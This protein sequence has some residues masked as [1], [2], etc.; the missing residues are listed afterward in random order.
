MDEKELNGYVDVGGIM[1]EASNR[2]EVDAIS[3]LISNVEKKVSNDELLYEN[4]IHIQE[5]D[6]T[7]FSKE[8]EEVEEKKQEE[9]EQFTDYLTNEKFDTEFSNLI[10]KIAEPESPVLS[11][12]VSLESEH[13][14][15]KPI[16]ITKIITT[17]ECTYCAYWERFLDLV[18]FHPKVDD[19]LTW[20]DPK[21]SGAILTF[22]TVSLIS[23]GIFSLLSIIGFAV[24]TGMSLVGGYRLYLTIMN[25]V[26]GQSD[27]TFKSFAS[28]KLTLPHD[29]LERLVEFI[30][31]YGNKY[32]EE[33]K[34]IVLWENLYKSGITYL[35]AYVIFSI[36]CTFNTLTLITFSVIF[37]FTW[38]KIYKMYRVQIDQTV[39][40]VHDQLV[41]VIGKIKEK[42]PFLNKRKV[43]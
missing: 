37:A 41:D 7:T 36:G 15:I 38:P 39:K 28:M 26:K 32:I 27:D 12:K 31:T 11:K 33:L 40:K 29:D 34:R 43:E 20:K 24:L 25:K 8:E 30:E 13:E 9:N 14:I 17:S 5:P 19:I 23:F 2:N 1:K 18:Y 35:I 42:L 4:D 21:I 10:S 16:E 22:I 3:E 6:S